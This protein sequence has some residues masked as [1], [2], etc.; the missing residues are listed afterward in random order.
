MCAPRSSDPVNHTAFRDAPV[1]ASSSAAISFVCVGVAGALCW[2]ALGHRDAS[3]VRALERAISD[4][5]W[6][7]CQAGRLHTSEEPSRRK[8]IPEAA[9]VVGRAPV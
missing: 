9:C 8:T 7:V 3:C 5:G 2:G 6:G 4:D 1:C